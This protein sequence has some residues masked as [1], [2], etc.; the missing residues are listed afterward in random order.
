LMGLRKWEG[1]ACLRNSFRKWKHNLKVRRTRT[2]WK[3][4]V[5]CFLFFC[6]ST[7]Y[8]FNEWYIIYFN[9]KWSVFEHEKTSISVRARVFFKMQGSISIFIYFSV[10][11]SIF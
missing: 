5:S 7:L 6:L 2:R 3:H 4:L 11:K 9:A 1:A 10:L 8:V